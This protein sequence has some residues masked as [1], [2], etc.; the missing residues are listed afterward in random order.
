MLNNY[1]KSCCHHNFNA[2]FLYLEGLA[3][4][5]TTRQMF[6]YVAALGM[7]HLLHMGTLKLPSLSIIAFFPGNIREGQDCSKMNKARRSG[8]FISIPF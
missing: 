8:S 5:L 3:R 2:R 7:I 6:Q 4:Y 1:D